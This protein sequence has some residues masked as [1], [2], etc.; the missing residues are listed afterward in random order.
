MKKTL[1]NI[2]A[3]ISC[4]VLIFS[5]CKKSE[6]KD[7]PQPEPEEN[8]D[9]VRK[10]NALV[11][12][13]LRSNVFSTYGR[14]N[15]T[16]KIRRVLDT[17]KSVGV[18]GLVLDVKG[19][20]GFTVYPSNYTKQVTSMDGKSFTAGVDYVSFM[21]S[22][23]KKRNFKIYASIVTFVE[24]DQARANGNVYEDNTFKNQYQ[25]IVCNASG[26]RVPITSTGKN[27]FVNPAIPE[28]QER[29]INIMKEIVSKYQ[30]DGL[31]LD[32]CRYTGINADFS[33]FSKNQFIKFLEDKYGDNQA[34][35][36]NFPGDIVSSWKEDADQ[37]VPATI[38]K[39]YKRWLLYRATVIH[40]FLKK[41][42]EAVKSVKSNIDFGVYVGAWYTTYYQVGVNWAS[43]TY[44]PFNDQQ[45]RF[46]WAYP[47][48]N[49]TGYAESLDVLLTGNYFK[50]L[51][52]NDN[53]ATAGMAY[54]WW[55]VEGSLKGTKYITRNKMPLYGSVDVGNV[56]WSNQQD[57]SKTIKYIVDNAS[58]GVMIFD[59]VH[60]YAPQYNKLKQPLWDAV[61]NGLKK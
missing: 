21:V 24:G 43:E 34:K 45:L 54:H 29:A 28:V 44:D 47:D 55:S 10:R 39:Y 27:G 57:I 18:N 2:C 59:V 56:D 12:V 37:I 38:G 5:A 61:R 3:A 23:A 1:V 22:E 17:L 51:M 58:G 35:S 46:D 8:T 42:R 26:Q 19:S 7:K 31:I 49:K 11:W 15:D 52:I 32:Y 13:D 60:I 20:S 33:D 14:F 41:A 40:D 6:Q 16:A 48:Y 53:P 50:Q 36:M 30:L 9:T 4:F 25:S